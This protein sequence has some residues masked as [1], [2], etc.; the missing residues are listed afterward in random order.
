MLFLVFD[1][2][3]PMDKNLFKEILLP[4]T[5]YSYYFYFYYKFEFILSHKNIANL[6]IFQEDTKSVTYFS[7]FS[8]QTCWRGACRKM[9]SYSLPISQKK[10]RGGLLGLAQPISGGVGR[11]A[12]VFNHNFLL[13]IHFYI[14]PLIFPS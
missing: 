10:G 13:Y 2:I 5:K 14:L 11:P 7:V 6:N 1:Q 4:K 3:R 12:R 9:H 8:R